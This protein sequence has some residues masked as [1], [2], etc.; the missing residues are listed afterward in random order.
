V[1]FTFPFLGVE[2][3]MAEIAGAE[4]FVTFAFA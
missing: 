3:D 2:E 1:T 4:G